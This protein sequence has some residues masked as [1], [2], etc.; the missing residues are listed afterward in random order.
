MRNYSDRRKGNG[1]KLKDS[2]F[3]LDVGKYSLL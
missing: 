3:S 2:G 1:F